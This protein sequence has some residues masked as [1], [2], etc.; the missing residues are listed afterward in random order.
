EPAEARPVEDTLDDHGAAEDDRED[1]PKERHHR[2]ERIPQHVSHRDTPVAQS[3]ALRGADVVLTDDLE[4][5]GP[6]VPRVRRDPGEGERDDRTDDVPEPVPAEHAVDADDV[7]AADAE[8]AQL[9]PQA[10]DEEQAEPE[11][12]ARWPGYPRSAE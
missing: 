10:G 7:H 4:D 5:L 11:R 12:R 2:N 3:L 1:P 8:P 6:Q 9:H